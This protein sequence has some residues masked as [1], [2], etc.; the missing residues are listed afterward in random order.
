MA[1]KNR[2]Q[3]M[4]NR[5]I[6]TGFA[7]LLSLSVPIIGNSVAHAAPKVGEEPGSHLIIRE[8][9]VDF[10][11]GEEGIFITVENFDIANMEDLVVTLGDLGDLGD[12]GVPCGLEPDPDV[13]INCDFSGDGLPDDGDYLLSVATSG[14]NKE[15]A[16]YDL[17]IGAVGPEG[18]QGPVGEP[19]APGTKPSI[20]GFYAQ[21]S[22]PVEL[23][24]GGDNVPHTKT[25]ECLPG[26]VVTGGGY[27]LENSEGTPPLTNPTWVFTSEPSPAE[28][29]NPTG[30]TVTAWAPGTF[31]SVSLYVTTLCADII[32]PTIP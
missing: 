17:T 13:I 8:V 3:A 21:T 19:G 28:A 9:H 4:L 18:L 7:A 1:N 5:L 22:D 27:R 23:V 2:G 15:V 11:L 31:P 24:T 12:I 29:A 20:V 32:I 16:T 26:D 25:V 10:T 30:W 6:G 14:G